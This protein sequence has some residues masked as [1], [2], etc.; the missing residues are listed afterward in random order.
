MDQSMSRFLRVWK[1]VQRL[2]LVLC[3]GTTLCACQSAP[4]KPVVDS[5][6]DGAFSQAIQDTTNNQPVTQESISVAASDTFFSTDNSV[7]FVFDIDQT[8]DGKAMP[9]VQT[10]PHYLTAEDAKRVATVLFGDAALYEADPVLAPRFTKEE[11]RE[12]IQ[13]WSQYTNSEAISTLLGENDEV[14]IKRI[15]EEI[16][17]LNSAYDT[18][19]DDF[20]REPCQWKFHK[21][22]TYVY[23]PDEAASADTSSDNDAIMAT[24]EVNGI[25]YCYDVVTRNKEDYKL[26]MISAYFD[27]R[28][29]PI[30]I[31]ENI[32]RASLTRT[33]P[34]TEAQ[35]ASV[36]KKATDMLQRMELGE[37]AIDRCKVRTLGETILEHVICI[38]AVPVLHGVAAVRQPQLAGLTSSGAYSSNYYMTGVSFEFSAN[39][40]LIKFSMYSPI[41]VQQVVNE[42][43]AMIDINS[44]LKKA[45]EH[46]ALSDHHEYG[47]QDTYG[48]LK[49]DL[50]TTVNVN[51]LYFGLL[52]EK[53]PN[54]DDNYYYLPGI[55]LYGV[56]E[57][58]GVESNQLYYQ[59]EEAYPIVALN[60]VDG[61]IVAMSN[62]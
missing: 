4:Q 40:D 17:K 34:P 35:I 37:W 6:N 33:A 29:S 38:D 10:I 7:E 51:E 44:L 62:E 19:Q 60:A 58:T 11:L 53:V 61:T 8:V 12:C 43:V 5:K 3:I 9:V 2:F 1:A 47:L 41:D 14:A 15:K 57:N 48:L 24:C 46:L 20:I 22:S 55:I 30:S 16:E 25:R 45:E 49:E 18:D 59:S 26:N 32:Y 50:K 28:K 23:A 13:R 42:N 21:D 52:R 31:D 54:T 36:Q 39:G 27:S 56:V